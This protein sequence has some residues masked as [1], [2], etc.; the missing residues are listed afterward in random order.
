MENLIV[1]LGK[2]DI[3]FAFFLDQQYFITMN[4]NWKYINILKVAHKALCSLILVL[5]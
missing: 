4:F 5:L 1:A 3:V 2:E